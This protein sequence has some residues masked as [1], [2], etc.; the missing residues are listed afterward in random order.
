MIQLL[1]T[2]LVWVLQAI[3]RFYK[4]TQ[5]AW[6]PLWRAVGSP[7]EVAGRRA[8]S[9]AFLRALPPGPEGRAF[10][11]VL[12]GM[13]EPLHLAVQ[14]NTEDSLFFASMCLAYPQDFYKGG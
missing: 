10:W 9:A 6:D 3:Y 12:C 14:C 7:L 1:T 11:G 8:Y 5:A 2:A 13:A 4:A